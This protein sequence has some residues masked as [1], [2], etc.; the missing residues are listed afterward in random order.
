MKYEV[1]GGEGGTESEI[2][3]CG[4]DPATLRQMDRAGYK[5]SI[6]GKRGK[7]PTDAEYQA[8]MREWKMQAAGSGKK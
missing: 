7:I 5:L 4:Y 6:D 8:A 3:F 1:V 2:P